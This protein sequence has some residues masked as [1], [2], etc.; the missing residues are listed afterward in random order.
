MEDVGLGV[1]RALRALTVF[2][3]FLP[4]RAFIGALLKDLLLSGPFC[5]TL[6]PWVVW[7][8]YV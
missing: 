8:G 7:K 4:V 2:S 5:S 1:P 6:G 3:P